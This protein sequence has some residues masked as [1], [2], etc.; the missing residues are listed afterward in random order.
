MHTCLDVKD[1][2]SLLMVEVFEKGLSHPTDGAV[3]H[4]APTL[5]LFRDLV[6]R[7]SYKR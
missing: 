2:V 1:R 6:Q 4:V 5:A 7:F 3:R